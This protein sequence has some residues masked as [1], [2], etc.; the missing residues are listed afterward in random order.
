MV[1]QQGN[2]IAAAQI[3]GAV[4]MTLACVALLGSVLRAATKRAARA[5][6]R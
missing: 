6:T 3:F 4:I 1:A 2:I 5:A